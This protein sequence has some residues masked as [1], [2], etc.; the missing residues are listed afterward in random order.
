MRIALVDP[1]RTTRLIVAR[2]LE[3]GCHKVVPFADEREALAEIK[4]DHSIEALITSAELKYMTG[5]ELCWETRL[6]AT[7]RR[8]IYVLM[9]SSQYDQRSLIEAL[10]SG[11]DDFIGKP[12]LAEE[13]YARLRAAE[14]IA[15]MQRELIRLATIDPLTGLCNRRG[16]FEQASEACA[17]TAPPDGSVSAIILDIDNFKQINDAFGHETGDEAIRAC[18]RATRMEQ[19]VTGRLGGDEFALILEKKSLPQA[20]EI[21][22]SLRVRL[23]E[24]PFDTGKGRIRLTCSLGVGE[25]RAGDTVDQILARA[26]MAL[27]DAKTRGRNCVVGNSA[28]VPV[29]SAIVTDGIVRAAMP[30]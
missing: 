6:L 21:A 14:R 3:A 20:V 25:G 18:A 1:S 2:M 5:V 16:F 11:A 7:S 12:P 17:R 23:A 13:L 9:M 28:M 29:R 22:E 19:A 8:P 4:A 27:Y 30:A 26:D 15:S 24:K 10:D